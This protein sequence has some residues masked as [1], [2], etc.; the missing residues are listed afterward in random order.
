MAY[1]KDTAVIVIE[2]GEDGYVAK[3]FLW[4]TSPPILAQGLDRYFTTSPTPF[5]QQTRIS[6]D[7]TALNTELAA[8]INGFV[9]V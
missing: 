3:Y 9:G 2:E 4:Q 1:N 8:F 5:I 6:A 7:K